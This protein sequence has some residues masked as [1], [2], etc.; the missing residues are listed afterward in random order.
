MVSILE[1]TAAQPEDHRAVPPYQGSEGGLIVDGGIGLQQLAVAAARYGTGVSL[2]SEAGQN[3]GKR[4]GSH[5]T[6]S[7]VELVWGVLP[8]RRPSGPARQKKSVSLA[9]ALV[10]TRAPR[11]GSL[12]GATAKWIALRLRVL[13]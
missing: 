1:D 2:G 13:H 3:G 12:V 10:P 6:G 11:G 9:G 7:P 4:C 5:V 8:S